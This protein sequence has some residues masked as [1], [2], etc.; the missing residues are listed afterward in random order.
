MNG[1]P[2]LLLL[3][4]PASLLHMGAVYADTDSSNVTL[5]LRMPDLQSIRMLDQITT[6]ASSQEPE[7]IPVKGAP[8]PAEGGSDL[9]VSRTG[10]GSLYWAFRDPAKAWQVVLPIFGARRVDLSAEAPGTRE[11]SAPAHHAVRSAQKSVPEQGPRASVD[12]DK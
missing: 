4:A 1:L 5:D 12:G 9:R 10:I 8:L 3:A 7:D 2:R 11:P 6:P